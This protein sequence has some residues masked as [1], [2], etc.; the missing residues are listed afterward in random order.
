MLIRWTPMSMIKWFFTS[1][2]RL[3]M[4]PC[5]LSSTSLRDDKL[6]RIT[7][8]ENN[9][10]M[11]RKICLGFVVTNK[12][13]NNRSLSRSF[14]IEPRLER[15]SPSEICAELTFWHSN[16]IC[17]I[18]SEREERH[19]EKRKSCHGSIFSGKDHSGWLNDTFNSPSFGFSSPSA[20][21]FLFARS[22][23][24][25]WPPFP[26]FPSQII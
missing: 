6:A 24:F 4:C 3:K 17:P 22:H 26:L 18:R 14:G 19:K 12:R 7:N 23:N 15:R 16:F 5:K 13:D 11:T 1:L 8:V 25:K 2:G 9:Y 10:F 20:L 21:K